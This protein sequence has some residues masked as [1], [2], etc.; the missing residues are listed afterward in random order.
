MQLSDIRT[1]VLNTGFD[2]TLFGTSR[3]NT[4]INS[5]YLNLARRANYYTDEATSDFS[6]VSGTSMYALPA[7]FART[8]S[9]H[10]TDLGRELVAVGLRDIDRSV[11][12]SGTPY[13][14]ALDG[15]NVHLYPTPDQAYP[16]EIR[17]WKLPPVLSAD[18]DVPTIPADYH[19][20]L[21]YWATAEA[22]RAE[23][24]HPTADKWQALYDK[25]LAQFSADVKFANG[26]L[27]TQLKGM[28]ES[29]RGLNQRG[30][31]TVGAD[32]GL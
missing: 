32:W 25:G 24:D 13:A 12:T 31:S 6:T 22:F 26:D 15:A 10:R 19:N 7:D 18:S 9:L 5:G 3:I 8:R 1:E 23:D 28:W 21:V 2:A 20:L 14:Y 29:G 11:I 16:L 17:Y 4:Y 30:W 27:P